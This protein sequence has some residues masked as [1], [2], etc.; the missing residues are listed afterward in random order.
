MQF[1]PAIPQQPIAKPVFPQAVQ[2]AINPGM[3]AAQATVSQT[4]TLTTNA[5]QATGRAD[6]SRQTQSSTGTG[7]ARD[8]EANALNARS[9][10]LAAGS[11]G[12]RGSLL[13]V[14]V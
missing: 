8:N 3:A 5:V 12:R 6:G 2:A 13:D 1:N 10:R 11:S 14:S 7:Q 4:P 9:N